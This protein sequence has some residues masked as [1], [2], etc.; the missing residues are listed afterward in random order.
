MFTTLGQKDSEDLNSK[1][2]KFGEYLYK[3]MWFIFYLPTYGQSDTL[4]NF[5]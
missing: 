3:F 2:E 5:V 4:Q 1:S